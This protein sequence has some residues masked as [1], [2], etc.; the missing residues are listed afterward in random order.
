MSASAA[1]HHADHEDHHDD[2]RPVK[3]DYH[4]GT[5][6]PGKIGMW[7]FLLSDALMFAGFLLAYA[8]LRAGTTGP[9]H[10]EGEPILGINFTAGLTFLLIVSSVTMVF[11]YANAVENNKT[12][13]VRFL[14]LTALGGILFL[15]GQYYE[16]FGMFG[17]HGLTGEGLHFGHSGYATTFY[18][19]T[20]FHG[21][22]VL[23]GVI[24]L[25]ITTIRTARAKG[26]VD[27]EFIE[28]V[29]LFWH[30][31]DLIWILVFTFIYLL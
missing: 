18:I 19:T 8:I 31:V 23:T 12:W 10:G 28:V 5:A 29:G 15:C 6:G 2:R 1:A 9:W 24:I 22:H 27:H 16:Y 7:I 25:L 13:A 26:P 14:A 20:S 3:P 17:H 21:M 11:A 4:T 30:F